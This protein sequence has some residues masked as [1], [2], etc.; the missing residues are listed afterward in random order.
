M[1]LPWR[2]KMQSAGGVS[3]L[4][5]I[6]AV[7]VLAMALIVLFSSLKRYNEQGKAVACATALDTARRQL[8]AD[9]MAGGF[10]ELTDEEAKDFVSFVMNGWDDLCPG[11]GTVYLVRRDNGVKINLVCGLHGSDKKLRTWLNAEY[12]L[13]QLREALERS[14][15]EGIPYPEF[16]TVTLNGKELRCELTDEETGFK[17][18]T[19]VTEG[20]KGTVAY[21]GI[22]GHSSFGEGLDKEGTLFYF[23]YADEDYCANWKLKEGWTGDSVSPRN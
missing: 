9:Y 3:R 13:K 22:I 10:M 14:R 7:L 19:T 6:V 15:Q 11:G 2:R 20:V 16:L 8:A 4:V 21:Y 17:Y 12:V 1:K 5:A 18:G 23:S